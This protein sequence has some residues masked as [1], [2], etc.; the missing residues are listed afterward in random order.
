MHEMYNKEK[1]LWDQI[2]EKKACVL[3]V[4]KLRI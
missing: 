3:S 1:L 2:V 4:S